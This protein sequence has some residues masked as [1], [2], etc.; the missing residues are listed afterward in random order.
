M[1]E[2]LMNYYRG[3]AQTRY[4]ELVAALTYTLPVEDTVTGVV[5]KELAELLVAQE[6][7]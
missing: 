6:D 7:S 3:E 2:Y 5:A 4:S 1:L